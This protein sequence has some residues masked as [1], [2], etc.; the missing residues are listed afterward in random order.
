LTDL[1]G[2]IQS[3]R[4]TGLL[5][6]ASPSIPSNITDVVDDSRAVRPGALFCAVRGTEQDGHDFVDDARQRG[7]VACL[8]TRATGA[9]DEIVVRDDRAAAALAAAEFHG[10]P[11]DHME[12]IGVTGTNGKS[13]TVALLRH[14]LNE[15]GDVGSIGT[16]GGFDGTGR[17]IESGGLTTP[18]SVGLHAALA[19]LERS[20]VRRVVMEVSSHALDQRRVDGLQFRAAI[21]TNITHDHLDYHTSWASYLGAKMRLT[22]YVVA[23]GVIV[24]NADEAHWRSLPRPERTTQ[25]T[26]GQDHD[27]DLMARE[28]VMER[29]GTMLHLTLSPSW[30]R[31]LNVGWTARPVRLP[32][33]GEF[34]VSN[35]LAAS[36]S[37]LALGVGIDDV[38]RRLASAPQV[39]GRLERLASREFLVLRDYAHTPDALRRAISAAR[40]LTDR[41]LVVVFGCGGDRDR[42]KRA[43]M[44]KIA[45]ESADLAIVTSDNPRTED[46]DRIIDDVEEGMQGHAYIR[47]V[48]RREAIH[49]AL[50]LLEPGDCLLLAGKGHET[51]QVIGKDRLPFDEREIVN[52]ALSAPTA[53]Q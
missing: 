35:A 51:Y 36:A 24:V 44:G 11:G 34:N 50:R 3:L 49:R 18:G 45:V 14:L 31:A 17:G 21:F 23:G 7:A 32:L 8:V 13:T 48:D 37:A 28:V 42:R 43:P 39:P 6:E 19:E 41:R 38:A 15:S 40:P 5:I 12:L 33:I 1:S 20:G 29:D 25:V 10:R 2:I 30:Q 16:L 4:T 22:E 53:L 46:P 9:A 26:F 27:A 52:D 47:V